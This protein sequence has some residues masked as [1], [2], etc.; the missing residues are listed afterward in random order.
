MS[1]VAPTKPLLIMLYGYPG[2]GKTFFARQLTE[3]FSAAH[4]HSERIRGE[5]FD[6]PHYDKEENEVIAPKAEALEEEFSHASTRDE[7]KQGAEGMRALA[8][9]MHPTGPAP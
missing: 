1:K 2:A 5:L 8:A 9:A 7:L 3:H 4:V 6:N